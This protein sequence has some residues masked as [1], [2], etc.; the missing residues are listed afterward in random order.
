LLRL[1][2]VVRQPHVAFG[3]FM[4][5]G[6]LVGIAWGAQLWSHLVVTSG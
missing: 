1:T 3:P 4:L 2:K 6:A 5:L